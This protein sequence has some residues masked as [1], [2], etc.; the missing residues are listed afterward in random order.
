VLIEALASGKPVVSTDVSGARDTIKE[1]KSGSIVPIKDPEALAAAITRLLD[2]PERMRV[3]GAFGRE[4]I[5]RTQDLEANAERVVEIY[6]SVLARM[7][8]ASSVD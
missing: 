5:L 1:G 7:R 8:K 6:R 3:M 2:D 4:N